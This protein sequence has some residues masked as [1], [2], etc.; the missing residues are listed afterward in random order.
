MSY[1]GSTEFYSFVHATRVLKIVHQR[2]AAYMEAH[3]V[4]EDLYKRR[5]EFMNKSIGKCAVIKKGLVLRNRKDS[6]Y[7]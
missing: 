1:S 3:E 6:Q 4:K 7:T 5:T 2:L